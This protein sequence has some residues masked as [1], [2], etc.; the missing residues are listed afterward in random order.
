METASLD[1]GIDISLLNYDRLKKAFP[2][3]KKVQPRNV[4]ITPNRSAGIVLEKINSN[5]SIIYSIISQNLESLRSAMRMVVKD[6]DCIGETIKINLIRNTL[7]E[8]DVR[9]L[10]NEFQFEQSVFNHKLLVRQPRDL[11]DVAYEILPAEESD[12]KVVVVNNEYEGN[13]FL[14]RNLYGENLAIYYS[15]QEAEVFLNI[16][17]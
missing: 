8:A 15:K 10:I 12:S 5:E 1:G 6:K 13:C 11:H 7:S 9:L 4:Y 17:R 3:L 2:I 14:V 16:S